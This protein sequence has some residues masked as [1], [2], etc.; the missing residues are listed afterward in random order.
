MRWDWKREVAARKIRA[1][2]E[3]K[4][5][6]GTEYSVELLLESRW[7]ATLVLTSGEKIAA[8]VLGDW[9]TRHRTWD[10]ATTATSWIDG[11]P[12]DKEEVV[13]LF[14]RLWSAAGTTHYE[15]REWRRLAQVL[16]R[17]GYLS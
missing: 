16:E 17:A 2:R 12:E 13:R 14:H 8:T 1:V 15:K 7:L 11:A 6:D 3:V 5:D 9:E 10:A 4:R